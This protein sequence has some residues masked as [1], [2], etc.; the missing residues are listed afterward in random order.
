MENAPKQHNIQRRVV[1]IILLLALSGGLAYCAYLGFS[2]NDII[3]NRSKIHE[4]DAL[5]I[6]DMDNV[7]YVLPVLAMEEIIDNKIYLETHAWSGDRDAVLMHVYNI[8]TQQG[9]YPYTLNKT[10]STVQIVM[11]YVDLSML[12]SIENDPYKWINTHRNDDAPAKKVT[13]KGHRHT[14]P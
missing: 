9:W 2:H 10:N 14:C 1:A 5:V 13:L 8:A 11:S 3:E 4:P 7:R 12:H 6:H